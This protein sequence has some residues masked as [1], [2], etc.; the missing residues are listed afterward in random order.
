M[1]VFKQWCKWPESDLLWVSPVS[2]R[3]PKADL[4]W[5]S[6]VSNRSPR[7]EQKQWP[8]EVAG[9]AVSAGVEPREETRA[10]LHRALQGRLGWKCRG[11]KYT[12]THTHTHTHRERHTHSLT[13]RHTHKHT[14]TET[15]TH[16][17][18]HSYTET[19][20]L[21]HTQTLTHRDTHTHTHTHTHIR[22]QS[23][24]GAPTHTSVYS[25]DINSFLLLITSPLRGTLATSIWRS[26][27][28]PL[29]CIGTVCVFLEATVAHL[30]VCC[31][32]SVCRLLMNDLSCVKCVMRSWAVDDAV[33]LWYDMTW[34]VSV[35][36]PPH[37]ATRT[38]NT[39]WSQRRVSVLSV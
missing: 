30:G 38:L 15:L 20:T 32:G 29:S 12:H 11:L 35:I 33:W 23:G 37:E 17:H 2:H 22:H 21:T 7:L 16:S 31:V 34:A 3:K 18:T 39:V 5:A 1:D 19:H 8:A 14:H 10:P 13:H 4:L 24:C 6:P 27:Q 25:N 28:A 9:G 26:V 36:Y